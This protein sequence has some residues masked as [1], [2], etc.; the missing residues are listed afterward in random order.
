MSVYFVMQFDLDLNQ[1][2]E[3]CNLTKVR[4]LFT[5][6]NRGS[7][8]FPLL[9]VFSANYIDQSN[10]NFMCLKVFQK[11]FRSFDHF[12]CLIRVD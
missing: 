1:I 5:L 9:I 12:T 7:D 8:N 4:P 6:S 11:Y 10:R 3:I 2:T